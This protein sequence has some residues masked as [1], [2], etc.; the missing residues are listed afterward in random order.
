MDAAVIQKVLTAPIPPLAVLPK[1]R[2]VS[3]VD[4]AVLR[5][6]ERNPARRYQSA[7]AFSLALARAGPLAIA[8]HA[9]VHAA[10]GK[11]IGPAR[12]GG[13]GRLV[14]SRI[15]VSTVVHPAAP[16]PTS[17]EGEEPDFE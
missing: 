5:A 12:P 10:V 7:E 8:T 11:L 13:R 4:A 15:E 14:P 16:D 6:L 3:A 17:T 9:E 1:V 2:V